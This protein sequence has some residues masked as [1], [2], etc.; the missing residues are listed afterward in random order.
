VS[1]RGE[2]VEKG[3]TS[4]AWGEKVR[5]VRARI[6]S[7]EISRLSEQRYRLQLTVEAL[8]ENPTPVWIQICAPAAANGVPPIETLPNVGVGV[9]EDGRWS[10]FGTQMSLELNEQGAL[11]IPPGGTRG[12]SIAVEGTI[13]VA[14]DHH[15]RREVVLKVGFGSDIPVGNHAWT[16]YVE[17]PPHILPIEVRDDK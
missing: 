8:N 5:G 1:G 17:T 11:K 3:A 13:A 12:F 4:S 15:V 9:K 10:G 7:G 6:A 2:I 16:G 14:S